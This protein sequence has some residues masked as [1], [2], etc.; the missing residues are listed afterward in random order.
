MKEKIINIEL[1][2]RKIQTLTRAM[3][4]ARKNADA[5]AMKGDVTVKEVSKIYRK[6][7][8]LLT[9]E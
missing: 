2:D 9:K 3:D 1:L 6:L 7:W 4:I 8:N 5:N